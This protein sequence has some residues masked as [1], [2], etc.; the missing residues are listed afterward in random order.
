[1][2]FFFLNR[3]LAPCSLQLYLYLPIMFYLS[4][5][6][7]NSSS[8][9]WLIMWT[10]GPGISR[11]IAFQ[12]WSATC[13]LV[14]HA[15]SICKIAPR[16]FL[17]FKQRWNYILISICRYILTYIYIR[18]HC[19]LVILNRNPRTSF[20]EIFLEIASRSFPTGYCTPSLTFKECMKEHDISEKKNSL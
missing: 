20:S 12:Y 13:L 16:S 9:I 1:M 2:I 6:R 15:C 14:F 18:H 3:L 10:M 4:S 7:Q 8:K 5:I 11:I 17:G 19:A